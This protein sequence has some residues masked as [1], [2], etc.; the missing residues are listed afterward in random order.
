MKV[1][2]EYNFS[3]KFEDR[4]IDKI[5]PYEEEPEALG[6]IPSVEEDSPTGE[7]GKTLGIKESAENKKTSLSAEALSDDLDFKGDADIL[8]L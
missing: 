6:K 4:D 8:H 7:D 2:S 1:E 5:S 3:M